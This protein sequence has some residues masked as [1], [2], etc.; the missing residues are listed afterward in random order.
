M[1]LGSYERIQ[2]L[3]GLVQGPSQGVVGLLR[4]SFVVGACCRSSSARGESAWRWHAKILCSANRL[5]ADL[6]AGP[7]CIPK[8]YKIVGYDP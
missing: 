2:G 8:P 1:V 5:V 6:G 7:P 4:G 3:D